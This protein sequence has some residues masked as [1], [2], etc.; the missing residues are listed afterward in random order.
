M[1]LFE[2]GLN[3]TLRQA[4]RSGE[5]VPQEIAG[6]TQPFL[7]ALLC[8]TFGLIGMSG[9]ARADAIGRYDCSTVATAREPVGDRN[10]HDIISFQYTCRGV[11]G[12]FKNGIV[13]AISV[14]ECDREKGTYLSSFGLH[15]LPDGFAAEQLLEGI[16]YIV[17][18]D[19]KVV[20]VEAYGKTSFK[21]ASGALEGLTEKA[22]NFTATPT[23]IGRFK[24]EFTD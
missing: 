15:R 11:D 18:E 5:I 24:L 9:V 14:A 7:V 8:S 4:V 17:L 19:D 22:V 23:G 3:R 6:M 13:A 16:G 2:E 10:E 1:F 12:L 20:G 21:F